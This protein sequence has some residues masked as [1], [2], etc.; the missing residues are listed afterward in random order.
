ML[1][2]GKTEDF[3]DVSAFF[4]IANEFYEFCSCATRFCTEPSIFGK[5]RTCP[6]SAAGAPG[7]LL[8]LWTA[9]WCWPKEAVADFDKEEPLLLAPR[10]AA[11]CYKKEEGRR[12]ARDYE[13][14]DG[15]T[16]GRSTLLHMQYTFHYDGNRVTQ[17]RK[18]TL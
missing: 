9:A 18:K 11:P 6:P 14:T 4:K 1:R 15:R 12:R 8:L 10:R 3:P 16:N 13:R 2:R 7:F 17:A 5:K